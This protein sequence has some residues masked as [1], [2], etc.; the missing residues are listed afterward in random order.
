MTTMPSSPPPKGRGCFFYGCLTLLVLF[1]LGAVATYFGVRYAI[2]STVNKYTDSQPLPLPAI[3]MPEV[4]QA[5]LKERL[6]NFKTTLEAGDKAAELS[7]TA[8]E[9]NA[10]IASHPDWQPLKDKVYVTIEG[11]EISGQVSIPLE[12]MAPSVFKGRY[13]NGSAKFKVALENG[14]LVVTMVDGQV[15]GVAIPE[16]ALVHMRNTNLALELEKN[17]D[18]A[19]HLKKLESIQVKEGKLLIRSQP[20]KGESP[21]PENAVKF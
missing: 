10:L 20:W 4:D 13:F 17:P 2:R 15:K 21:S 16:N 5:A 18:A 3:E 19:A 6:A 11:S 14:K 1:V 8:D 7:L 9:I 12:Q